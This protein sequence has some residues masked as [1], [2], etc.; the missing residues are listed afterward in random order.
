MI[1]NPVNIL[2]VFK[3][4]FVSYQAQNEEEEERTVIDVHDS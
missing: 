3:V 1:K 4:G 2:I